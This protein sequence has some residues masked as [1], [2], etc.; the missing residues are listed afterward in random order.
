MQIWLGNCIR[1]QDLLDGHV[2]SGG[3]EIV[4]CLCYAWYVN[5]FPRALP[6]DL[7]CKF[8]RNIGH[9][10]HPLAIWVRYS[11]SHYLEAV[12]CARRI[13]AE[14]TY[15][16]GR[17]HK[18]QMALDILQRLGF[19][20]RFNSCAKYPRKPGSSFNCYVVTG[21]LPSTCTWF[22]LCMPDEFYDKC[23]VTAFKNYY[24][25]K[26]LSMKRHKG[27]KRRRIS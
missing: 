20:P 19:P 26:R 22:P 7:P 18:S 1:P 14:Y 17:V 15:R 2:L 25:F 21:G 13:F 6:K 9:G 12:K 11:E 3:Q 5:T 4:M 23:A 16:Y 10:N 27:N 24:D 8:P